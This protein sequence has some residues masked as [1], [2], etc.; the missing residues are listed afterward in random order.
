[1]MAMPPLFSIDTHWLGR[2]ES[3]VYLRTEAPTKTSH[4]KN[5]HKARPQPSTQPTTMATKY[6]RAELRRTHSVWYKRS[7]LRAVYWLSKNNGYVAPLKPPPKFTNEGIRQARI[8]MQRPLTL[9]AAPQP[10]IC[11]AIQLASI[12]SHLHSAHLVLGCARQTCNAGIFKICWERHRPNHVV[13]I[14]ML[15]SGVRAIHHLYLE[16]QRHY[17]LGHS[18]NITSGRHCGCV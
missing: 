16:S 4:L 7:L 17:N 5:H 1:M 3:A 8:Y 6:K 18:L 14:S 15:I 10:K 11:A 13:I 12:R 2:I 9:L